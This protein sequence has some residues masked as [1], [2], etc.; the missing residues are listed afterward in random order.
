[1]P[2]G[3]ASAGGL[4]IVGGLLSLGDCFFALR[5]GRRVP[6]GRGGLLLGGGDIVIFGDKSNHFSLYHKEIGEK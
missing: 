5:P 6:D 2:F 4:R 3:E 1:M